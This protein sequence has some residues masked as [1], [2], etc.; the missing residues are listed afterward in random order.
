MEQN[1]E[2][3]TEQNPNFRPR[4]GLYAKIRMSV[5]SANIL[6]AVLAVVLVGAL[7]FVS[8]HNGFTIRFETNGGTAVE[9]VKVLHGETLPKQ[10][11]PTREGYV[12]TGWY[13]DRA[14]T[15]PWNAADGITGS[16]T[17]YAG[18]ETQN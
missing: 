11:E 16:M 14:C 17:L 2:Q 5:K 8:L 7:I 4:G 3:I 10:A 6:V 15:N 12:F 13:T 9:S 18:W 1:M